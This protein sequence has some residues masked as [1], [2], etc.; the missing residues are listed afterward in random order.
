[1]PC[2][3]AVL[4]MF[5][6]LGKHCEDSRMFRRVFH[7]KIGFKLQKEPMSYTRA[8][9]LELQ[10]E[11]LNPKLYGIHSLQSGAATGRLA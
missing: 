4:E 3:L 5:L 1:M 11:G 8:R 2:T 7:T 10:N 6:A 9:E